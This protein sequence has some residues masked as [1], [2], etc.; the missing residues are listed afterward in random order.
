MTTETRIGLCTGQ[1]AKHLG[2]LTVAN[3]MAW[4]PD[5]RNMYF[6]ETF[7]RKVSVF[8]FDITT[9]T[10][11]NQ[12]VAVDYAKDETLGYPDGMCTDAQGRLWV[13]GFYG[14]GVTCFDPETGKQL[15]QIPIPAGNATSCCFGGPD[16]NWLFVTSASF[17]TS[18][19]EW[20]TYPHSGGLFVVK[21]LSAKGA[22][23][24]RFKQ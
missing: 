3:G 1:I 14:P 24:Y 19:E 7:K 10:L 9:G 13:C 4:S 16:F 20:K 12:R 11:S 5:S 17:A 21:D 8:D 23:A 2:D 18:E 6:I 15:A 22:P